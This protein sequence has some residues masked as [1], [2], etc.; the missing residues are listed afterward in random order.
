MMVSPSSA[1]SNVLQQCLKQRPAGVRYCRE[2]VLGV[3]YDCTLVR[4]MQITDGC[5]IV[6]SIIVQRLVVI[7]WLC[8][9][10]F[11]VNAITRFCK[12]T[13]EDYVLLSYRHKHWLRLAWA[14]AEIF[15]EGGKITDTLKSRHVF[16]ALY[17]KSTLFRA[18]K[19]QTKIFA[20]FRDVID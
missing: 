14:P 2:R 19:A 6:T 9:E 7:S 12:I 16:G 1:L 3:L 13:L 20:F 10:N 8:G 15:P 11:R 17:T 5:Q 4:Q 18:P